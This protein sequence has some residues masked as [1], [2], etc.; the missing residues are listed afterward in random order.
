MTRRRDELPDRVEA[1]IYADRHRLLDDA[2]GR[3]VARILDAGVGDRFSEDELRKRVASHRIARAYAG[4]YDKP[5]VR[6]GQLLLGEDLNGN[7]VRIP[8]QWLNAHGLTLGGSGSGKT[9]KEIFHVLQI[10]NCV[11]GLWLFDCRKVEYS[12]F[13]PL[14]AAVG[15]ALI[16]LPVR[17]LKLNPLQAPI[18]V[19]PTDWIARVAALLVQVLGL[20]QRAS[21]LLHVALHQLYDAHG[22]LAGGT[23]HPTLFELFEHVRGM[24]GANAPA[25]QAVLDSLEP[26]LA[27]LGPDVLSYRRG[28][29]VAELERL[30]IN[31]VL[32][33]VPDAAQN[34]ILGTLL[35]SAFTRRIAAGISNASMDLYISV[36]EGQRLLSNVD[37][38]SNALVDLWPL[39]RGTGIGL[40]FSVPTSHGLLAE[41]LSF[42]ATKY[43]GRVGSAADMDLFARAMGLSREQ[44]E[45]AIHNLQPG[46]FITQVSE[47]DWRYPFVLKVPLVRLPVFIP[48][49]G[50][51]LGP[52]AALPIISAPSTSRPPALP[53]PAASPFTDA[54]E[55]AFCRA[56]V[57]HPLLP[58]SDYAQLLGV[59]TKTAVGLRRAL[60]G[61]GLV[62]ERRLDR[63]GR[64][65]P[66]LLLEI[67]DAGRAAVTAHEAAGGTP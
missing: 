64:G 38:S 63:P 16:S 28:W 19:A 39:V 46:W 9:N 40:S 20:P 52:L 2:V 33:G 30:Q 51:D 15:V 37:A 54:R 10:A 47:G 60:V 23:E 1:R 50:V 35:L 59:S 53:M 57:D 36:D 41:A 13:S 7:E 48:A 4:A 6:R 14:L 55:A 67:T 44:I 61:R 27:A 56:V 8:L 21:K 17:Y 5:H 34:L 45:W 26:V 29:P 31:F 32:S 58:S 18:G 24:G 62:V 49:A 42:S 3:A 12:R 22:I 25:R 43:L 65:R 66:A 11:N